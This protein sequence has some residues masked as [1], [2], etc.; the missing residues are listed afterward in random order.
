MSIT[1]SWNKR[2]KDVGQALGTVYNCLAQP[3]ITG[4]FDGYEFSALNGRQILLGHHGF[5]TPYDIIHLDTPKGVNW[6]FITYGNKKR[7][8][9]SW[10]ELRSCLRE[11]WILGTDRY[12]GIKICFVSSGKNSRR[13][14]DQLLVFKANE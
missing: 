13:D 4:S 2:E 6:V 9:H 12:P 8:V 10:E 11:G 14:S 1:L 7:K 3:G 5:E